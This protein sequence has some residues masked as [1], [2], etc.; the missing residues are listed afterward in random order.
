MSEA[1]AATSVAIRNDLLAFLHLGAADQKAGRERAPVLLRAAAALPGQRHPPARAG[2]HGQAVR[3][4]LRD[5]G[6]RWGLAGRQATQEVSAM[7]V[8]MVPVL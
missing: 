5:E 7:K 2:R 3:H 8:L 1:D 6:L 4:R